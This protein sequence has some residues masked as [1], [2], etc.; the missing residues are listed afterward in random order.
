[1]FGLYLKVY[2]EVAL[3]KCNTVLPPLLLLYDSHD[4]FFSVLFLGTI[5]GK[6]LVSLKKEKR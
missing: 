4:T 1:M 2:V 6:I 3:E 5:P